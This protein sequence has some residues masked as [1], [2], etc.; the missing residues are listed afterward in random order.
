MRCTQN[1]P[2]LTAFDLILTAASTH[3][4][5]TQSSPRETMKCVYCVRCTY[6]LS[7]ETATCLRRN[8]YHDKR[9]AIHCAAHGWRH[10]FKFVSFIIN[11]HFVVA[12]MR[13]ARTF[14]M[15]RKSHSSRIYL[16]IHVLLALSL[17]LHTC[18]FIGKSLELM[19]FSPHDSVVLKLDWF[20]R[21]HAHK[22]TH[23]HIRVRVRKR[24]VNNV[25]SLARSEIDENDR[26][27][28]YHFNS[29]QRKNRKLFFI[30]QILNYDLNRSETTR[31]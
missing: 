20:S 25:M 8:Q 7:I 3:A 26:C 31:T 4:H 2:K 28:N 10:E 18:C 22:H 1:I 30:F 5:T 17:H 27:A 11:E 9:H 15:R 21:A 6:D 16:F 24:R 14:V 12:H 19:A 23:T 13:R 29:P